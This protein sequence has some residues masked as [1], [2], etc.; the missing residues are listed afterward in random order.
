LNKAAT[1][2]SPTKKTNSKL[3]G[4]RSGRR[5]KN[6]GT[7]NPDGLLT[8]THLKTCQAIN[9]INF[10]LLKIMAGPAAYIS[11]LTPYHLPGST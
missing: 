7:Q 5:R 2:A 10:Q 9:K 6:G 8:R 1:E 4:K 3:T 11:G